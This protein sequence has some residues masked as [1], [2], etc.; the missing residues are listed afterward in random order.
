MKQE[1]QVWILALQNLSHHRSFISSQHLFE[2]MALVPSVHVN[3]LDFALLILALLSLGGLL[4]SQC[5]LAN[6]PAW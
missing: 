3:P 1:V 6:L 5:Q 2:V 4:P